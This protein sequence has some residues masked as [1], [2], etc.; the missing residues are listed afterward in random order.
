MT[1]V[2]RLSALL[3]VLAALLAG[4][5][6][7]RAQLDGAQTNA[8]LAEADRSLDRMLREVVSLKL[9]EA[10]IKGFNERALALR[11]GAEGLRTAASGQAEAQRALLDA[12]GKPTEGQA[13]PE[14]VAQKRKAL[15]A[16][17]AEA[18]GWMRQADLVVAK[19]EQLLDR[20]SSK[21]IE[22]LAR[23]LREINPT[24]LDPR[25]WLEA[26]GEL[27]QIARITA[28]SLEVWSARLVAE[29]AVQRGA[30]FVALLAAAGFALGSLG[31]AFLR[32]G[33]VRL[34][35]AWGGE[36]APEHGSM[37][38]VAAGLEWIGRA[39]PWLAGGVLAYRALPEE[40]LLPNAIARA[41]IDG[42]VLGFAVW[43]ALR[44]AILLALAPGRPHWRLPALEQEKTVPLVTGLGTLAAIVAVD[45]AVIRAAGAFVDVDAFLAL[46]AFVCCA[47]LALS[48]RRLR[49]A[50]VWNDGHGWHLLRLLALV[51]ALVA[52]PIAALGFSTL[53]QYLS[54]GVI[55]TALVLAAA[56]AAR[57]LVREGLPMLLA[58]GSRL[59]ARM[60]D[61]LSVAPEAVRLAEFWTSLALEFLILVAT[62]V[63]LLIVWGATL[64]DVIVLWTRLLEGVRIGSYTFSLADVMLASAVFVVAITLTRYLQRVLETRI[65]PRT[66][67]DTGVRHSLR[68]GLGYVGLV[69]A[70]TLSV[71]TLGLNISN[72]AFVA[73]ALSV[74]I[75]FGL[76]N[77]VNNFVSGLILL[78]ERPIKQGDWVVVG[79]NQGIVKRIN[80]RAT[81]IE[82]FQR[83][84]ILVPNA[85]FLQSHVV[86]WTHKDVSARVDVTIS[87]PHYRGTAAALRD[88][89]LECVRVRPDVLR[90]PPPI[91]LLKDLTPDLYVFDVFCFTPDAL[92]RGFIASELR[93][94]IDARLR[95]IGG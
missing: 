32:R 76:Q 28:L 36:V 92:K 17:L 57:R 77:I 67:L 95:E 15:Q 20:L 94:A 39:I 1:V 18:E 41:V 86:N 4:V 21:R 68:S 29:P 93:F 71:S 6:A 37:R 45:W 91:V 63:G 34:G 35:L 25:N 40:G 51:V 89:L 53:A 10:G 58:P 56:A 64:D 14:D 61:G 52:V 55:G 78:V 23:T 43:M 79:Q 80:V 60:L 26:A 73:G 90:H 75:G 81:E 70:A 38:M 83:S 2:R 82:T 87:I 30:L 54:L 12:L 72:L 31:S 66:A 27:A 48:V 19:A 8:Q 59:G 49:H 5:P 62:I 50:P 84:T 11:A 44:W 88:L 33:L 65:F 9:T 47:A 3:I 46:W 85:E 22:A 13:E 7:A 24:P 16:A 42:A 74:G 69:L